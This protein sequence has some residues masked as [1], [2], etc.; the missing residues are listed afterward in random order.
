[1]DPLLS[2]TNTRLIKPIIE[3]KTLIFYEKLIRINVPFFW[4]CYKNV[5]RH[6]KTQ[7]G[8]LQRILELRTE[9]EL[10]VEIV[11]GFLKSQNPVNYVKIDSKL[12][13]AQPFIKGQLSQ[14]S[15]K[16]LALETIHNFYHEA[17]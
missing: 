15:L 12:D 14:S 8:F 2:L 10:N 1:M 13:L 3:E 7:N 5:P 11:Q 16:I 6:L 4:D 9:L 17:E